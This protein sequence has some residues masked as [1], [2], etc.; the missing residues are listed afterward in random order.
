MQTD[1]SDRGISGI[2]FQID[3]C[4][5][6]RIIAVVS[7]GLASAE[8][9][10]TTTEKELL[11]I[12][13]SLLKLQVYL[14]GQP[15][16][17][18]TDHLALTFLNKTPFQ[19]ARISR[20]LLLI[21]GYTFTV[22]YCKGKDN[23]VADFLSR[24]PEGR[25]E[26]E[27]IE[28]MVISSLRLVD[29]ES[30]HSESDQGLIM[31]IQL[32]LDPVLKK[33]LKHLG[34]MQ[35]EDE[36]L[37]SFIEKCKEKSSENVIQYNGIWF[38]KSH[39]PAHWCILIPEAM[40]SILVEAEHERMGHLGVLK[41]LLHLKRF[42][43][44]RGMQRDVKRY[45]LHCDLCQRVKHMQ[46]SMEGEYLPV[47]SERPGDLATVDFYGPLPRSTGGVQYI[48]VIMDAFSKLVK[49]YS[50][51]KA[52]ARIV[53]RKVIENYVKNVG[54]PERILSDNGS[55]FTARL[56]KEELRKQNIKIVYSS[57]RHP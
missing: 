11:A 42:Y 1:A 51:K 4:E 14:L 31:A 5:N 27:T 54:K 48:F 12:V 22:Q 44:W 53:V 16:V 9:R 57:V 43:C 38:S 3:D 25:F 33:S 8:V 24:N 34:K 49:L 17:I 35:G 2:L 18:I 23:I 56:W 13:Y 6:K 37:T 20:W 47:K 19:T 39:S 15:F 28:R 46:K 41:T 40:K 52:T 50:V 26:N 55:Q 29:S 7:R 36:K 45:V 10:Y 32:D 30:V 21:Q